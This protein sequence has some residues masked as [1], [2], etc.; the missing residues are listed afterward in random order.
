MEKFNAV[1][2]MFHS[3]YVHSALAPWYLLEGV[4]ALGREDIATEVVEGTV[5]MEM[6]AAAGLIVPKAP[7]AIGLSCYIWNIT[8]I[9]KLLP[10]VKAV[11]P[12][13]VV[14]LGGPEVSYNAGDVLDT[15]PLVDYVISGEGE[16]PFALL[17]DALADGRA[18][19]A[20][21][22]S[23]TGRTARRS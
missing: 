13:A 17:L 1:I 7:D 6:E 12:E 14:I 21:P 20:S 8:F 2:C 11:L 23:V 22:A 5:N 10:I 15:L 4:K 19:E 3:S 16:K 18:A 9:K